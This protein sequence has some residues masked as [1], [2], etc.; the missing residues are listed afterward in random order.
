MQCNLLLSQAGHGKFKLLDFEL[1]P[2]LSRCHLLSVVTPTATLL[3]NL[4]FSS[5]VIGFSTTTVCVWDCSEAA[6]T[7][8]GREAGGYCDGGAAGV[9]ECLCCCCWGGNGNRILGM[10]MEVTYWQRA[11]LT[12]W[13]PYAYMSMVPQPPQL[14]CAIG[15]GGVGVSI[16]RFTVWQ[17]EHCTLVAPR[18]YINKVRHPPQTNCAIVSVPWGDTAVTELHNAH[19]TLLAPDGYT[20]KVW[21]PPHI[22]CP[23][24][25]V[26]CIGCCWYGI[27]TTTTTKVL[28]SPYFPFPRLSISEQSQDLS[29]SRSTNNVFFFHP[30]L[31]L[32]LSLSLF[33]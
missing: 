30:P 19:R 31:S 23:C 3:T 22:S 13:A 25:C 32:S 8:G 1:L 9:G 7:G 10:A 2:I 12:E 27:T 33:R 20:N 17:Q 11:H 6:G 24:C 15:G 16:A 14:I 5:K 18:M 21:Q 28:K 29:L 4:P 26:P